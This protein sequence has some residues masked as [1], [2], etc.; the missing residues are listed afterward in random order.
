MQDTI[1]LN[2][3]RDLYDIDGAIRSLESQLQNTSKEYKQG[4][5]VMVTKLLVG[6]LPKRPE[7]HH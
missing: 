5:R 7:A 4:I 2:L 3:L 1:E 6:L